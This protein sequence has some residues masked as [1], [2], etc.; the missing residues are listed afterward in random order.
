M[1]AWEGKLGGR[2]GSNDRLKQSAVR[3]RKSGASD[4]HRRRVPS[5]D[6]RTRCEVRCADRKSSGSSAY[7]P[8]T[9]VPAVKYGAR[10]NVRRERW[11][12]APGTDQRL[13]YSAWHEWR[14]RAR[15]RNFQLCLLPRITGISVTTDT[16]RHDGSS[17]PVHA[18]PYGPFT[19][20]ERG[21]GEG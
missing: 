11:S 12:P 21:R 7:R 19:V 18:I 8:T 13:P 3:G 15:A 4:G 10:P 16:T 17:C 14:W 20:K 1:G 5:N 9:T 2:C 6:D